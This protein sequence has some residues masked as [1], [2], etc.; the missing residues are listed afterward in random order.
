MALRG[1]SQPPYLRIAHDL[2]R[3]IAAGKLKVGDR[4][5]SNKEIASTY[6]VASMTASKATDALRD[7]GLVE[8][9]LG[10]GLFVVRTPEDEPEPSPGAA[11]LMAQ[12]D[13]LQTELRSMNE[14][15]TRLEQAAGQ[16]SEDG[17]PGR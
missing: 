1:S 6:D 5:P 3:Q 11:A 10:S 7:E 9:R 17:G 16:R 4:L 15:L 2:R 14:R 13:Q 12:L 8:S